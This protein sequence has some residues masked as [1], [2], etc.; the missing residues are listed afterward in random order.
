M[1]AAKEV[2][3]FDARFMMSELRIQIH[4]QIFFQHVLFRRAPVLWLKE[5]GD[6]ETIRLLLDED[7][8]F[9]ENDLDDMDKRKLKTELEMS[10]SYLAFKEAVSQKRR[11][12][13]YAEPAVRFT[14]L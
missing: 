11:E 8:R 12:T 5:S 10:Q 7:M 14:Y 3:L 1:H 13:R 2:S 6:L 4:Y 9:Y